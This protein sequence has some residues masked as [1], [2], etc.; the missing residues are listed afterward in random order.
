M[1]HSSQVIESPA[2]TVITPEEL[3]E[4][5]QG[6]RRVTRKVIEAFPED[7]IATYSLAGMRPCTELIREIIGMSAYGVIG[8]ATG[9][10]EKIDPGKS[11]HDLVPPISTKKELLQHWDEATETINSYWPQISTKRFM[12]REKAFGYWEGRCYS[13]MMYYIDN[14]IHHR[15]QMYVYLRSLGIKPPEFGDR[16]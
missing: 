13:L 6:H 3:L 8:I 11:V 15:G 9:K 10:W 16:S 7:K 14:E 12:E 2:A 4:L 5:W 1:E